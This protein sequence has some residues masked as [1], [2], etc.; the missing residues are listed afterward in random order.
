MQ[1]LVAFSI[2]DL[3]EIFNS[4][5]FE[6]IYLKLTMS[7]LYL[8]YKGRWSSFTNPTILHHHVSTFSLCGQ[9]KHGCCIRIE[10]RS[11]N[12]QV[13]QSE[14]STWSP[15]VGSL[16][17]KLKVGHTSMFCPI[18][19]LCKR[20]SNILLISSFVLFVSPICGRVATMMIL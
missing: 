6:A 2:S 19:Q 20:F 5:H 14:T 12:F 8:P 7:P 13:L 17:W 4:I 11:Q 18:H 16:S 10:L 15:E 1:T 9:T 3:P